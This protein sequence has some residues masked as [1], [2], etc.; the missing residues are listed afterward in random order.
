[1]MSRPTV[2]HRH[3]LAAILALNLL[4]ISACGGVAASAQP[5][6]TATGAAAA[7]GQ[8]VTLEMDGQTVTMRNGE[9]FLLQ[10]GEDYDWTVVPDDPGVI[11]RVINVMTIRGSQGLYEAHAQGKTTL[12][13][14]G[15]PQCRIG[16]PPCTTPGRTFVINVVVQ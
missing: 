5:T 14:T 6:A 4:I 16:Q 3:S 9:R 13:A 15:E 7:S 8:T 11:S 2:S 10:L 12:R 1:M